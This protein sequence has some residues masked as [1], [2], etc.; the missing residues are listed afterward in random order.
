MV[1][2]S[3]PPEDIAEARRRGY[4]VVRVM[5]TYVDGG[6]I[7]DQRTQ[8]RTGFQVDPPMETW[9]DLYPKP[10]DA[11]DTLLEKASKKGQ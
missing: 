10:P 3:I 8:V 11:I 1:E 4:S 2:V 9:E 6:K 5:V 7:I